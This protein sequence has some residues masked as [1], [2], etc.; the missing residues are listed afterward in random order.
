MQTIVR[1]SGALLGIVFGFGLGLLILDRTGDLIASGNR[2]AFLVAIVVAPFSPA[3]SDSLRDPLQALG[4][5]PPVD[6]AGDFV[7]GVVAAHR[8][9]MG[10][11]IGA[12]LSQLSARG[13]SC[14][15]SFA[16]AGRDHGRGA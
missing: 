4:G 1:L 7:L 10:A 8:S 13:P 12:P 3:T 2:P 11:L 16:G 6:R 15:S 9:A 14:P 5:G